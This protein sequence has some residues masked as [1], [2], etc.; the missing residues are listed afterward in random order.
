MHLLP[1]LRL[2]LLGSG[3]RSLPT[4]HILCK[5]ARFLE[6]D[7]GLETPILI[8]ARAPIVRPDNEEEMYLQATPWIA[9]AAGWRLFGWDSTPS[10]L[11]PLVM[12]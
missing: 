6:S 5:L 11:G 3:T 2:E 9:R 12:F 7:D 4:L 10:R 8:Q 1:A